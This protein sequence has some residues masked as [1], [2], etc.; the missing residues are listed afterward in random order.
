MAIE[1]LGYTWF[2]GDGSTSEEQNP[3]HTYNMPGSYNW[4]CRASFSNGVILSVSGTIIV[5]DNVYDFDEGEDGEIRFNGIITSR[6]DKCFRFAIPQKIEQGV[7]W[8]VYTGDDFPFPVGETGFCRVKDQNEDFH[9]LVIDGRTF[10]VHEMGRENQWRDGED[11]YAGSEIE[12]QILLKEE[13]PPIGAAAILQHEQSHAYMKPWINTRR[14]GGEYN[15]EGFRTGFNMDAFIRVNGKPT[16][17]A[18]TQKIPLRGQLTFDRKCKSPNLQIG[19]ILRY[20]PWRFVRTQTWYRQ[21]D[22]AASPGKKTM[23]EKDWALEWTQPLAWQARNLDPTL[24]FATGQTVNMTFQGTVTGP[25]GY[26]NTAMVFGNGGGITYPD[27]NLGTDFT[28]NFWL[29]NPH[30]MN[31]ITIGNLIISLAAGLELTWNDGVTVQNVPLE[32]EYGDWGMLTIQREGNILRI[33]ENGSLNNTFNLGS[34]ELFNG[35]MT[36]FQSGCRV[37]DFI[38][39]GRNVIEDGILYR[40]NDMVEN[41]GNATCPIY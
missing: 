35:N 9:P 17:H 18:I 32:Q 24:D 30:P 16:N 41:Q 7:G 3:S 36:V 29:R 1:F 15:S 39:V 26:S 19:W 31:M 40:Y 4:E 8:S 38:T 33:Y 20:A 2:F 11:E 5:L 23:T 12:S 22:S 28:I 10:Q 25:D 27:I 14:N 6:T 13:V 37:S 21:I 34:V